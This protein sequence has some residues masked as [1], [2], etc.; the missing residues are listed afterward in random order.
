MWVAWIALVAIGSAI[1]LAW[2]GLMCGDDGAAD[3]GDRNASEYCDVLD[4]RLNVFDVVSPTFGIG[5]PSVYFYVGLFAVALAASLIALH[6]QGPRI[7]VAALAGSAV[8]A[9][10][11]VP[12][13]SASLGFA[14]FYLLPVAIALA[15]SPVARI[16]GASER[17]AV[18]AGAALTCLLFI[19]S[20]YVGV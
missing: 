5:P 13:F 15:G 14:G 9:V 19:P 3:Y 1:R 10:I 11:I 6:L 2:D 7:L 8:F 17:V 18:A 12:S 16:A 20:L 4:D